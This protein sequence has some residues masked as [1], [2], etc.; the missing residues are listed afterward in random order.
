MFRRTVLDI[1]GGFDTSV[2]GAADYDLYL[3]IAREFRVH[4]HAEVILEYRRHDTNMTQDPT[5]MLKATV[6]VLSAQRKHVKANK[7]Y[8]EA[9]RI[10]MRTG[11]DIY[12]ILLADEVRGRMRKGDWSRAVRG[13]LV[14]AR[15]HPRGLALLLLNEERMQW[16][17]ERRRLALRL[18]FRQ[19]EIQACQ[20]QL[21]LYKQRLQA[22]DEGRPGNREERQ[23]EELHSALAE[24]HQEVQRLKKRIQRL[25]LQIQE[26][27]RRMQSRRISKTRELFKRLG[28]ISG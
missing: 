18:R 1:V 11:Q 12:G 5:P 22:L 9:Y 20:Q 14:L 6:A 15:Y 21:R 10:G 3:R 28:R 19:Q 16:H 8:K 17:M 13:A 27:D 26:L 24:E 2:N 23:A 4:H 25:S 7:R